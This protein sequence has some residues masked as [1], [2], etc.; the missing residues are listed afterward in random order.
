MAMTKK[1]K[2]IVDLSSVPLTEAQV[3]DMQSAIEKAI[4]GILAQDETTR[5]TKLSF[6]T[7][8]MALRLYGLNGSTTGY[9]GGGGGQ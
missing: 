3:K 8:E 1:N 7:P 9:N 5:N 4:T 6:V 2:F